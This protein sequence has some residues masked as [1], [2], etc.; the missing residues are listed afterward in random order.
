MV[1]GP[2]ETPTLAPVYPCGSLGPL[3]PWGLGGPQI[4]SP[5]GGPGGLGLWVVL[6][7]L[8]LVVLVDLVVFHVQGFQG[9]SSFGWSWG[10]TR[11]IDCWWSKGHWNP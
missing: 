9:A 3:G 1:D 2:A 11:F 5:L 7:I 8:L 6:G 4:P 10:S